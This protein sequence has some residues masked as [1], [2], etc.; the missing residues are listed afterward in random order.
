MKASRR[1]AAVILGGMLSTAGLAAWATPRIKVSD[2]REGFS[3]EET[4]PESFGPWQIDRNMPVIVPPPDQQALLN[5]IYNQTLARTYIN[6]E[7]YRIMLS[8]AYG[9]DQSDGLT[10]HLPEVCYVGQGFRMESQADDR[11]SL[12][13]QVI[14]V[15]RLRATM[16]PRIEPITYWVTTGNEATISMWRRRMI[17]FEYGLRRRIPD[18]LLVRVSSIDP[19]NERAFAMHDQFL[20]DLVAVMPM[21]KRELIVGNVSLDGTAG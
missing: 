17:S 16:G 7:R 2:S 15:R 19:V 8:L 18:G 11:L 14:P 1:R 13:G 4:I 3:L 6:P 5:K 12:G 9:G 20:R 10:V 21:P